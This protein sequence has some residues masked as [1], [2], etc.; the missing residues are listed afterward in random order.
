MCLHI[1]RLTDTARITIFD[2]C[3]TGFQLTDTGHDTAHDIH[4]FKPG[5]RYRHTVARTDGMVLVITH[6]GADMTR[7]KKTVDRTI[8]IPQQG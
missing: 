6:D 7:C 8:R 1:A 5:D 2:V 3:L 4:R